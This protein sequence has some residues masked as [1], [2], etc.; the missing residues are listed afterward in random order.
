MVFFTFTSRT[1]EFHLAQDWLEVSCCSWVLAV[2]F[3]CVKSLGVFF[4][5]LFYRKAFLLYIQRSLFMQTREISFHLRPPQML[6]QLLFWLYS[7]HRFKR[8]WYWRM[9]L[10][11]KDLAITKKLEFKFFGV[12]SSEFS[13]KKKKIWTNL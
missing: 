7:C 13:K 10:L 1:G 11:I 9:D 2:N 6:L 4:F 8:K 12:S 3:V 5:S